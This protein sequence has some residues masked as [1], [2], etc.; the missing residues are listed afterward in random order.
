MLLAVHPLLSPSQLASLLA[1]PL[2]L[3][4][5]SPVV[6]VFPSSATHDS[7]HV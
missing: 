6:H 3:L 5:L 2:L 7:A 1:L 4:C